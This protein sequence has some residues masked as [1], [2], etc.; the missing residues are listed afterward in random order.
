L[1]TLPKPVDAEAPD[2]VSEVGGVEVA[3]LERRDVLVLGHVDDRHVGV[4][5]LLT[6]R[7]HHRR[8]PLVV[9]PGREAHGLGG[10]AREPAGDGLGTRG[11]QADGV[12][13]HHL[14]QIG[15]FPIDPGVRRGLGL[16][17]VAPPGGGGAGPASH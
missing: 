16:L 5:V 11:I 7:V 3:G 12:P 2:S 15:P 1:T 14:S 9:E 8:E 6:E 4:G 13:G 10:P 17:F